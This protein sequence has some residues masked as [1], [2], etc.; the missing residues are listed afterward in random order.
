MQNDIGRLWDLEEI[1][2]LRARYCRY[3]DTKQWD[4]L[5]ALFTDDAQFDGFK[6]APTG[7]GP[8]EFIKGG[9]ARLADAITVHQCYMPDIVF[10]DEDTARGVWAMHDYLEWPDQPAVGRGYYGYGHYEEE[11]R[12]ID[13]EWRMAIL[14]LRRERAIPLAGEHPPVADTP[15]M[16]T[17]D[18][19]PKGS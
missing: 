14:R 6:S 2:R 18:W 4:A 10:L 13:G 15:V 3:L 8:D 7:S 17:K 16:A 5:R 1:K 12:R 9:K 11:Y 19:L